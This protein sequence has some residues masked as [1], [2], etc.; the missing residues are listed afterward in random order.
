[1]DVQKSFA[2][3]GSS[4]KKKGGKKTWNITRNTTGVLGMDCSFVIT[5]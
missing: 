1:M 4:E 2:E 5:N 3:K